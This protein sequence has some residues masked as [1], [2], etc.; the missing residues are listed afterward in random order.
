M[1]D[2]RIT[3]DLADRLVRRAKRHAIECGTTLSA[4][5][6]EAL[7]AT[8]ARSSNRSKEYTVTLPTYG[9]GG[10]LSGVDLSNNASVE[11]IMDRVDGPR[12]R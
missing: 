4:V 6:Q 7:R 10:V 5:I 11:D 1:I 8:L 12:R 9:K 3:I 2:M